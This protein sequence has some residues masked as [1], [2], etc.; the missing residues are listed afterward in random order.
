MSWVWTV[1]WEKWRGQW[2]WCAHHRCVAEMNNRLHRLKAELSSTPPRP[3]IWSIAFNI[4]ECCAN[5]LMTTSDVRENVFISETVLLPAMG[6]WITN[7]FKRWSIASI[8]PPPPLRN[9]IFPDGI[10][11][12][13]AAHCWRRVKYIVVD[14]SMGWCP[15]LKRRVPACI[16]REVGCLFLKVG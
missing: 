3:T 11:L 6:W 14:C 9:V 16:L 5:K 7:S 4:R 8:I 15:E 12:I 1:Y 13:Q 2:G 10:E